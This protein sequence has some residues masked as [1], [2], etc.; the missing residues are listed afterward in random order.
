M[1][2]RD[3]WIVP[4]SVRS[5]PLVDSSS[6]SVPRL[7]S[8][9]Q[10]FR[11]RLRLAALF[12]FEDEP[13]AV[14][15]MVER[16]DPLWKEDVVEMFISPVDLGTYYELEV[17]PRGTIFDAR[18]TFPGPDRSTMTVDTSWDC[19]EI[20]AVV[21]ETG[22]GARIRREILVTLPFACLTDRPPRKGE[23]WRANFYRI[24]RSPAGDSFMAWSPTFATPPDFHVPDRFGALIF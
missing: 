7:E 8:H 3:P 1:E 6:G 11:D 24:D 22:S 4:D 5:I 18:V 12:S 21:R 16:D 19:E 10:V 23:R 20:A 15:T 9:V 2:D 13:E 17:S 14:A